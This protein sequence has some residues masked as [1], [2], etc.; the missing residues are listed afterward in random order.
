[1]QTYPDKGRVVHVGEE[2]HQEPTM[3]EGQKE[4]ISFEGNEQASGSRKEIEIEIEKRARRTGSPSCR[5]YHHGR[6]SSVQSPLS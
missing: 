3:R 6:G 5:S 1:M 2:T 4:S